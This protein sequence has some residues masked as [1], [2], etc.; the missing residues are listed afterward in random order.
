[1]MQRSRSSHWDEGFAASL[2]AIF[3]RFERIN[4]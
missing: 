1:M 2:F 3:R 4:R